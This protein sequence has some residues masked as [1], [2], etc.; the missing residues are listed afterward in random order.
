MKIMLVCAAGMSTSLLVKKMD[1]EALSRGLEA[2]IFACPELEMFDKYHDVD[3]IL[4]APQVR[5]L[6]GKLEERV[7]EIPVSIID[8]RQYGLLDAKSILDSVNEIL[9]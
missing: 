4:L 5:F 7:G 9:K 1:E 2:E 3:V 8:M 6:K